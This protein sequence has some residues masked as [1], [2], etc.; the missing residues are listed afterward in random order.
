MRACARAATTSRSTRRCSNC[1]RR[2]RSPIPSASSTFCRSR[3]SAATRNSPRGRSRLLPPARHRRRP[4]HHRRRRDLSRPGPIGL[5]TRVRPPLP[6]AIIARRHRALDLRSRR[7]GPQPPG[8]RCT[9]PA[10]QRHRSRRPQG[11]R[12]GRLLRR[13]LADLSRHG[14]RRS[15]PGGHGRRSA[16][17]AG[18][19]RQARPRFG[20]AARRD[21]CASCSATQRRRSRRSSRRCSRD[22][23]N[24]SVSSSSAAR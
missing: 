6:G 3:S 4:A 21:A 2:A 17:A 9:L 14:A 12:H 1:I 13:R 8:G 19:D 7:R 22:F 20:G 15:G 10:A 18:Q 24:T 5:G 23:R 16:R 11:E